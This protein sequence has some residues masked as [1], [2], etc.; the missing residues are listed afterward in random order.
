VNCRRYDEIYP[1]RNGRHKDRRRARRRRDGAHTST[2]V[3]TLSRIIAETG[4]RI[5]G[6]DVISGQP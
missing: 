3:E 1:G 4:Q 2:L 5:A 6:Q